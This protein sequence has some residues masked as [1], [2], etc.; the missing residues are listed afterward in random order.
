MVNTKGWEPIL[1]EAR[2]KY[3]SKNQILVCM[4]ELNELGCVLAKFP[5]YEQESTAKGVLH[6]AA[7]DEITDVMIVLEHAKAILGIT[8]DEIEQRST[9][10]L[11]RLQRWLNRSNSMEQTTR[12]REVKD[13]V[14]STCHNVHKENNMADDNVCKPCLQAQATEGEAP[15]YQA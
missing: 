11:D 5:R 9:Q 6:D 13:C 12:D 4:E 10:K 3:G 7:V 15:N 2:D 14:C 1:Q 8:D